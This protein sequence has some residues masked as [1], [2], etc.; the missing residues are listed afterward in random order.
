MAR[1]TYQQ[2]KRLPRGSFAIP[3]RAPGAGSY[4]VTDRAHARAAL[5]RVHQFGSPAE[6][7]AVHRKVKQRFPGM[8]ARHMA[9]HH[10]R[11]PPARSRR[12]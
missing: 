2:R 8:L 5:Q 11:R 1:L 10:R 9:E 6:H 12:S 7:A 3:S 4:P